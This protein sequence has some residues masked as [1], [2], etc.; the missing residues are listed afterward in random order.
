[1]NAAFGFRPHLSRL[2]LACATCCA[3]AAPAAD[4][5]WTGAA[6]S[7]NSF[8][9]LASNWSPALPSGADARLLL[10]AYDTTL[11]SGVFDVGSVHGSRQLLVQG[12]EL[13]LNASG[14]S[15]GTLHFAGGTI[16]APGG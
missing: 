11:R 2:A 9:D 13:I 1:M 3:G 8:W 16:K 7:S 5:T 10:G 14:S 15:L 4:Y 6:G 12:G